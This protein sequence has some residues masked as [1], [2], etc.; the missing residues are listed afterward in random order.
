MAADVEA[1]T[2]PPARNALPRR[3]AVKAGKYFLRWMR[4][5]VAKHSLCSPGPVIPRSERDAYFPWVKVLEQAYPDIR[6]ELEAVLKNPD[7]IPTFHQISPDQQR[8]SKGNNWKTFG[9]YVYG[10]RVDE[11]CARCPKTTAALEKLPGMRTAMF[12][13]LAPRYHIPPHM[14]PTNAVIRAHLGLIVPKDW[15]NVWI[16]VD[17]QIVHWR[18]GEV[19][20]FD[21]SYDHE[22]RND[23]DESRAV[24]FIDI[25]RP[26]DRFGTFV[27]GV[28]VRLIRTSTYVKRPLRNLQEW[29]RQHA[30][31]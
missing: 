4:R 5:F 21:D 19:E 13:I 9:F 1:T 31:G 23:T 10:H 14:G 17:D 2:A 27:N 11:N 7:D 28:I 26:M 25:D 6:A 3:L 12:S 29:N 8:I 20:L 30:R 18:E 22:V 15:Q 24:L 16:R